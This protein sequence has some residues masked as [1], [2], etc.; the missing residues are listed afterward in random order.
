M[1]RASPRSW[2]P[3]LANRPEDRAE[4][5]GVS[6]FRATVSGYVQGV[7]FR[8][9]ARR[10]AAKLGLVGWVRNLPDGDVEVLAEGPRSAIA[11]FRDW[12]EEGPPGARV[13]SVEA[14]TLV[15]RGGYS[16]FTVEF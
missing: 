5:E 2:G 10:E 3:P 12:L 4:G 13:D 11:A 9:S 7:G 15:P 8:Y 16:E 14:R 1:K 6:A